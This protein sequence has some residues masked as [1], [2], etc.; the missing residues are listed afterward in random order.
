MKPQQINTILKGNEN[1][2]LETIS[3]IELALNIQIMDLTTET[4]ES[5]FEH[6]LMTESILA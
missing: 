3:R 5:T 2:T 1:L 4:Y 6:E